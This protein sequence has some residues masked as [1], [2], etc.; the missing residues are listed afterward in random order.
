MLGMSDGHAG[1]DAAEDDEGDA[2]A[3]AVLGDEL[4]QPDEEHGAGGHRHDGGKGGQGIT[5]R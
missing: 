4:A 5:C 3:D 1:D 2:V